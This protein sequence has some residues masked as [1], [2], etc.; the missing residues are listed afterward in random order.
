MN[1]K[2]QD[3]DLEGVLKEAGIELTYA[4]NDHFAMADRFLQIHQGDSKKAGAAL[5]FWLENQQQ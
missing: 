1:R 4:T 5:K 2:L 3:Y